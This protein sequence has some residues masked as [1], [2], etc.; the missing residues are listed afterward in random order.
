MDEC[1]KVQHGVRKHALLQRMAEMWI[2]CDVSQLRS[3][4]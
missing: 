3:V 4:L 2:V 1:W